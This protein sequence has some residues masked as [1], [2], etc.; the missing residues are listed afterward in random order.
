MLGRFTGLSFAVDNAEE[1]Y[2][3]QKKG[4]SFY[5]PPEPQDWGGQLVHFSDPSGNVLTLVE[6]PDA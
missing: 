2:L 4:V 1:A 5:G 3:S 6:L